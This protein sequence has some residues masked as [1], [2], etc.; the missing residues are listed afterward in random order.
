[1]SDTDTEA[2]AKCATGNKRKELAERF[3]QYLKSR[4]TKDNAYVVNLNGAW[5]TGKTYFVTEWK[6][7]V[8]KQGHIAIK[9]DA[10][11]SDYLNDPLA[12]I[13]A[14]LLEQIKRS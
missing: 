14:E 7:L 5:G 10:R 3:T 12:I 13:I 9:I 11:E 1:M 4:N 2:F 8:E 6:K